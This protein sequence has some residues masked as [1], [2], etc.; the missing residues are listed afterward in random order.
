MINSIEKALEE[1]WEMKE[2]FYEENK[3]LS[4]MEILVKLENKYKDI[5]VARHITNDNCSAAFSA[6]RGSVG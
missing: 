1:T 4:L 3:D 6:A 2:R 5:G